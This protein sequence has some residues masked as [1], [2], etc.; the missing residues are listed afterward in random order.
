MGGL[1][2]IWQKGK[3]LFLLL[4]LVILPAGQSQAVVTGTVI[5]DN[6][7]WWIKLTDLPDPGIPDAQLPMAVFVNGASKG[8]AYQLTFGHFKIGGGYPETAVIY[9]TGYVRLTPLGLPYGP[10]FILGP[11]HWEDVN[12][13]GDEANDRYFHNLQIT[14]I[15]IDTSSATPS[16]PLHIVI[17]ANDYTS[18]WSG[19]H[20]DVTHQ[21]LFEEPTTSS[22]TMHVTQT[23]TVA[24]GAGTF[25]ISTARQSHPKHEGFKWTQISSMYVDGYY[26]DSDSAR[27]VNSTNVEQIVSFGGAACDGLIFPSPSPLSPLNSWVQA[28]HSDNASWQGNTPNTTI[29]LVDPSL[30]A[31]TTPQGY[32][33]CSADYNNDNVGLWLNDD[34]APASFSPGATSTIG[35]MLIAQDNPLLAPQPSFPNSNNPPRGLRPLFDWENVIGATS[36]SLQVATTPSFATLVLNQNLS[37]SA[38]VPISDL[39]RNTLLFWRVR[40]NGPG[41]PGAWS[42]VRHFYSP[43]PPS[44]P[45]PITPVSGMTVTSLTPTLDWADSLPSAARYE[46]QIATDSAFANLLG[47]GQGGSTSVSQFT[48][49]IP[50]AENR[51]YYW[52]VRAVG[53]DSSFSLTTF[54]RWSNVASFKTGNLMPRIYSGR[55]LAGWEVVVG[56]GLYTAPGEPPVNSDDI[57]TVHYSDYS[58]LRTNIQVRR[59]M[60]HNITFKRIVDND[61]LKYVHTAIVKFRLPFQPVCDPDSSMNGETIE[62]H[63]AVWDGADTRLDYLVAFQ[64]TVNPCDSQKFGQIWAWDYPNDPNKWKLVGQL[65][66]DTSWHEVQMVLDT[67]ISKA[68]LVIDGTPFQSYF[69]A[70]PHPDWGPEIAAR[71]AAEAISQYPGPEGNGALHKAQF[72]DWSWVWGLEIPTCH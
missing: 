49:E 46:V 64:W 36:Y 27:T 1:H 18:S 19:H 39:P 32:F 60:A 17:T 29:R 22:A 11:A 38:Y 40:T 31:Q 45:M 34:N 61:S 44:V 33:T 9:N 42:R 52:R 3:F 13:D 30:A 67:S 68:C 56:D 66:V 28:R 4:G 21:I 70:M 26:H 53:G 20:F 63:L 48:P 8:N 51:M 23:Q 24:A 71:F 10:S 72:K 14:R 50:L 58:E 47:R 55:N 59:V 2:H 16:G 25:Y 65:P 37:A 57:E 54:S 7:V 35:Y 43:N 41:G 69:T 62:G 5:F 15:D 12:H 6:T